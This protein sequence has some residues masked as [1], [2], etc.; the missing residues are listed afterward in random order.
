MRLPLLR[1]LTLP[2]IAADGVTMQSNVAYG[3]YS[4][5]ALPLDVY[6]P[7]PPMAAAS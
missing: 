4:G 1:A 7:T 2:P 6:Q 3:T 5:A